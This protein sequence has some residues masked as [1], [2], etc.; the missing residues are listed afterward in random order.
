[1]RER[2]EKCCTEGHFGLCGRRLMSRG[3]C[4]KFVFNMHNPMP[5]SKQIK[6]RGEKRKKIDS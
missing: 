1:M 4:I 2:N 3:N 5:I 6:Y